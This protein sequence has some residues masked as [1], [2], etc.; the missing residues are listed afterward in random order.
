M[1]HVPMIESAKHAFRA[2]ICPICQVRPVGS[3]KLGPSIP[4]ICE[5][6]CAI[7][8]YTDKL[9]TIAEAAPAD[10]PLDY[11]HAIREQICNGCCVK[12]TAGDYC[13]HRLNRTCPLSC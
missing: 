13:A 9:K 7:F 12:P 1:Q 3:E 6:T 5:P 2:T 8:R 10:R 11:E 4:R